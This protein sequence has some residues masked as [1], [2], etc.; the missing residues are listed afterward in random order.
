[1]RDRRRYE[2]CVITFSADGKE[3]PDQ[4][5]SFVFYRE[6]ADRERWEATSGST[7]GAS[8]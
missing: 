7:A 6:E 8:K 3:D 5:E 4:D 1:V 2:R